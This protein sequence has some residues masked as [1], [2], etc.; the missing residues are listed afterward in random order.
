ML[1][2]ARR[3]LRGP[4]KANSRTSGVEVLSLVLVDHCDPFVIATGTA[5]AANASAAVRHKL[6]LEG[7][8]RS[9][10]ATCVVM[11]GPTVCSTIPA[12]SST[13]TGV[14]V[15]LGD[16]VVEQASA[17]SQPL[18]QGIVVDLVAVQREVGISC[19]ALAR[20]VGKVRQHREPR[21]V[22]TVVA[23]CRHGATPLAVPKGAMRI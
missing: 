4:N 16:G 3:T 22:L 21:L 20:H 15:V 7:H 12:A 6:M 23:S 9:P 13:A 8:R 17:G 10:N 19:V 5:A 14:A 1:A 11:W 2:V 18:A